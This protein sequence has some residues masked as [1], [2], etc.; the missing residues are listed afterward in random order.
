M[1]DEAVCLGGGEPSLHVQ[2]PAQRGVSSGTRVSPR[3]AAHTHRWAGQ[4]APKAGAVEQGHG[5]GTHR[6]GC[7]QVVYKKAVTFL[8]LAA[9]LLQCL[10]E[11]TRG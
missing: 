4:L 2:G 1:G 8:V 3:A 7:K 10:A 5:W 11:S 6:S 9:G